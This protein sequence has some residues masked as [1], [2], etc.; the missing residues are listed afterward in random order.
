MQRFWIP[1]SWPSSCKL[2]GDILITFIFIWKLVSGSKCAIYG[3][4]GE[5]GN[6]Q[7][8]VTCHIFAVGL[9]GVVLECVYITWSIVPRRRKHGG[10]IGTRVWHFQEMIF[11]PLKNVKELKEVE[12]CGCAEFCDLFFENVL[13]RQKFQIVFL[14]LP[15]KADLSIWREALAKL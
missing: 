7:E 11:F 9:F 13:S 4:V 6:C 3:G 14:V 5:R 15:L 10:R 2:D 1:S 12:P 8:I